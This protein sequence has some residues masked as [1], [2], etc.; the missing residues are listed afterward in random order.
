MHQP[1][2][3]SVQRWFLHALGSGQPVQQA[4]P[5]QWVLP[6]G[7]EAERLGIYARAYVL[8]LQECLEADYPLTR[9]LMGQE[10][11]SF[12]CVHYIRQSPSRSASLYDFGEG[13]ADFLQRSQPPDAVQLDPALAFP[14]ALARLERGLHR[15][16][17]APGPEPSSLA[18]AGLLN[19]ATASAAGVEADNTPFGALSGLL[20]RPEDWQVTPCLQLMESPFPL[21]AYWIAARQMQLSDPEAIACPPLPAAEASCI[22]LTRQHYRVQVIE[23]ERWQFKYLQALSE[24][25]D[26]E[27]ILRDLS[28]HHSAAELEAEIAVW[29]ATAAAQ[30][31][32]M[33][34]VR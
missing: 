5:E 33:P 32:I 9:A 30:S 16:M 29:S 27:L 23:L 22:A 34:R 24:H 12:F 13:F 28:P 31:L 14:V 1:A 25:S 7:E 2:L 11:F 3:A 21:R 6:Q 15:V 19:E 26:R 4:M 8:R 20:R 10:L 17:R 18:A